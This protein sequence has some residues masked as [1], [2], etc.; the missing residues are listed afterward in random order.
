[1]TD[2][3]YHDPY[4]GMMKGVLLCVHPRAVL[5]DLTHEIAPQNVLQGALI[6]D[7]AYRYFPQG[8]VFVCVVD[9]GVGTS[10]K[11]IAVR[12]GKYLFVGPDNG[13]FDRV[14]R[15]SKKAEIR[16]LKNPSLLMQSKVP[17]ATFHGRDVFAP[18][19][20]VLAKSPGRFRDCG[21][22]L[23]R[24]VPL[25]MPAPKRE[26]GTLCGKILYFDHFGNA[27][28]NISFSDLPG[29]RQEKFEVFLKGRNLGRMQRTYGAVQKPL[30]ALINS[31]SYV[32][33]A[34]PGGSARDF[35]K[36]RPGDPVRIKGI[37]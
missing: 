21:P 11:A 30:I 5:I 26:G 36:L 32:E 24:I 31:A 17:S 20:A 10:R 14:V 37:S 4:V 35:G 22:A 7:N 12:V 2:F 25:R 8:S 33:I 29:R 9:P 18:A 6:L 15:R 27:I 23:H 13:L 28:T 3:G 1:M 19:A 16:V 34:R